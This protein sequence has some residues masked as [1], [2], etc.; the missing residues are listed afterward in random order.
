MK[1]F[2]PKDKFDNH[3][4]PRIFLCTTGGKRIGELPAY[5][6]SLNAKWNAYSELT[7]TID[8]QYVDVLT[9]ET[10]VHPLFDKAEGLRQ[11]LVEDMGYFI[12]QDPNTI[13]S[14]K[15]RKTLSNFSSEYATASKY[16]ENFRI[17][18]GDVDS[19][20]IIYEYS[21]YG[22]SASVD[23]M[24]KLAS[25]DSYDANEKYF[26]RVYKDKDVYEYEQIQITDQDEYESHFGSDI[27]V[28][29]VLYIHGY[30]NVKF[31]DPNTPELSLLHLVFDKIP[32]WSIGNVDYNLR[33]RERKFDETRV[34][35]YDFLMNSV[36]DTFKCVVE[37]DTL[38]RVVN[39]YEEADDGISDDGTIQ[40]RWET[41]VYVSRDNLANEI[42]IRYSTDN[43][44]T[45]LKVSGADNLD[46]REVNIGKNYLL[47]LDYY[48]NTD[49]MEQDIIE[50]YDRY[51][52][53][54]K[55][56]SQQY[57][58]AMQ[59]WINAYKQYD[60]LM[61]AVPADG[62]VVLVGDE[63]KKLYCIYG[64]Y[65]HV[66]KFTEDTVYY[67]MQEDGSMDEANPQP[68]AENFEKK[69]YY[70]KGD[71]NSKEAKLIEQLT[72][73]HVNEDV[74]AT[75]Q[76]NILLRLKNSA[77]DTATVR[78]YNASK[79]ATKQGKQDNPVYKI[80]VIIIRSDTGASE[81]TQTY[82]LSSWINGDLRTDNKT[83]DIS[84]L[85][86]FKI[87]YIG[88]MGAYFV[89]AKD[90][91][92][93]TTLEEYGINL[94]QE[95]HET[96]TTIFRTQTEAMLSKEGYQCIA[97]STQP[98]DGYD[99]GTRWLD[100]DS[101]PVELKE[102]NGSDWV[103]IS[104]NVS[105]DDQKNYENYQRYIDN[106]N[107]MVAVQN[108]LIQ[109]KREA[110]YLLNGYKIDRVIDID[111]LIE[112]KIENSIFDAMADEYFRDANDEDDDVIIAEGNLN[113]D[114]ITIYT[115][116]T[117]KLDGNFAIYVVGTT[118]YISYA[119]SQGV[120]L[121][122]MNEIS[123]RTEFEKFFS[124]DQWLALS[125]LI[126]EDEFSDDNFV[127]TGYESE[128]ERLKI[129]QELLESADKTLKTL[130][131]P[132]LEFS[133][134]MANIL[135]LPE[136]API[137]NQFALGNFIR[138]E[139]RPGLV[140]R[141]RLLDVS[142]N[143]D[144]LADFSAN[145]GNLVT[146]KSEVD[147]HAELLAQAVQAGKTV[148]TA[149]SDWQRAVDKSNK[150]EEAIA[151]GLQDATLQI[152]RASGQAQSWDKH[153]MYFRKFA[154]GSTTQYDDEQIAIIN[155]KIVFTNDGWKTSK[156]ALGEFEIDIDGDGQNEKMYGLLADAVV[157]GYVKG[158]VIEGG[159]M[160]I[161]GSGG[162]FVVHEDGSVQILGPDNSDIY[163][164]AGDVHVLSKAVRYQTELTYDGS[165]IFS[166][167]GSS[168][169][170]TCRVYEQNDTTGD[171][172]DITEKLKDIAEFN[173][174]R[175]PASA[176]WT[177]QA[178][179]PYPAFN[180]LKIVNDDIQKNS[181]FSCQ[182]NFDTDNIPK[183]N[184]KNH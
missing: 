9:G 63:F 161:G 99:I 69:I 110:E 104:A 150:L 29:D 74:E 137:M 183:S 23:Q 151:N 42:N 121:E 101:S 88:I 82:D 111:R 170:I 49:W 43:I 64:L 84:A 173:W 175:V 158:S 12:I 152:G 98:E 135:A 38:N 56:Y 16:L 180:Q 162:K 44:K 112:E 92:E 87:S 50:S 46:I 68:T 148:A 48:H 113:T 73:Y 54:A 37:W 96:Y 51:L 18:T 19:K 24:Y 31:Y 35:V 39:F 36:S 97:Q 120:Y 114:L 139:L 160:S 119:E 136:F 184:T 125:P 59:G 76:D 79:E 3:C 108:M 34:A 102:Y 154:D 106:Y 115:F 122:K 22:E 134:N 17:N 25:Y 140:K 133:V 118:P 116:K 107:K 45:K 27:P 85:Q 70:I 41:D 178:D 14:D 126:R 145:F 109:K 33:Y 95:K 153:G 21:K 103:T 179:D 72:L 142:L 171:Y 176:S 156:A 78:I 1:L 124:K 52:K 166:K 128:E 2:I 10:K 100:T 117:S 75:T 86:G 165:T 83:S 149:A 174:M 61:N 4:P 130:S 177:P 47:N 129:C 91:R 131:Q 168:C 143:F 144:S 67:V 167:P 55:E 132:S 40:S 94:L 58:D 65:N 62:N 28:E 169:I 53:S 5:E 15:D 147:L 155:N 57:S 8:R 93:A 157:S 138:I 146:T 26:C 172:E 30:A 13:Y 181:Q 127:L 80:Q 71:Y 81:A 89:L 123:R 11:V 32:E 90:E 66:N 163:A 60:N 141:A 20:E 164:T 7:F 77:N 6:S 105:S 159:S 182:V